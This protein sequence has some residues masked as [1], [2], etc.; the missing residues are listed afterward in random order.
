[1]H[2][3]GFYSVVVGR[4]VRNRPIPQTSQDDHSSSEEDLFTENGDIQEDNDP[5]WTPPDEE[6]Y[7]D[8]E[9][10]ETQNMDETDNDSGKDYSLN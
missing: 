5:T 6:V 3:Y 7:D 8:A 1:M 4:A 9:N 10:S 2:F